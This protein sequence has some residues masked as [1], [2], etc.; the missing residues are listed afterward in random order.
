MTTE[1]AFYDFDDDRG[2]TED[3]RVGIGTYHMVVN[4]VEEN[5]GKDNNQL[6]IEFRVLSPGDFQGM[7]Y[8]EYVPQIHDDWARKKRYKIAIVLGLTTLA[9]LKKG[10]VQLSWDQCVGREAIVELIKDS[11]VDKKGVEQW[12]AR[13]KWPDNFYSV[14]NR[15]VIASKGV[16]MAG[17][18][19][20]KVSSEAIP[21]D[22]PVVSDSGDDEVPF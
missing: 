12:R 22:A 13:S 20:D 2:L 11:W 16:R 4:N 7:T 6:E 9:E 3:S 14:T 18:H 10:G 15:A 5:S 21:A 8:T 19:K 1:E 17:G